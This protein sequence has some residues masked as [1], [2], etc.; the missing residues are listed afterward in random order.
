MYRI[1]IDVGSTYVK[2]C[3]MRD[4]EIISIHMEK[5]PIRQ[6]DFFEKKITELRKK[7][8]DSRIVSCGYGKRNVE[9][10]KNINELT[11][12]AKGVYY[13]T[14][15][16]SVVLDVGGQDTKIISQNKGNLRSFFV[17]DKCAAG[18]GMF[19]LSVLDM[20]GM[21]FEEISLTDNVDEHLHLSST[22]AVF[23]QSEIVE[24]IAD[25]KTEDEIIQSV[26]FQIFVK[27]RPLLSKIESKSILIT[28]GLSQIEGISGL[29]SKALDKDCKVLN[30]GTYLASIGC[31]VY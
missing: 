19:L 13:I 23:A 9:N 10:T 31:A 27:A 6:K 2:Y 25:N 11:A 7:Y 17:N 15:D 16:D 5:T 26:L 4:T 8:P 29:A 12:L 30:D 14:G 21:S 24:L 18:S 1:G 28:G 20:I 22:C 3:V